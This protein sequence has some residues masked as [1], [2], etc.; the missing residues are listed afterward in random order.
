MAFRV[1]E[2][3]LLWIDSVD[4]TMAMASRLVKRWVVGEA[5]ELKDTLL[6]AGC[7]TS[8][9]GRGEHGWE[10]PVGGLY[11]TWLGWVKGPQIRWVPLAAG[12]AAAEAVENVVTGRPIGIKWP[13]D[14][15]ASGK[16]L[17]GI[18]C[19]ARGFGDRHWAAVGLGINVATVPLMTAPPRLEALSLASLVPD[20]D[21]E[22]A[23]GELVGSFAVGFRRA[24]SNPVQVRME[25]ADR[26]VHR[27]GDVLFLR[28]ESGSVQGAFAGFTDDGHLKLEVAGRIRVFSA[29]ELILPLAGESGEHGSAGH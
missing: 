9:R 19:Q 25:W 23:I 14:L 13:N 7:Q 28:E 4:S 27:T 26:M 22:R 18:V 2:T 6:V 24:L 12:V 3:N 21:W 1:P 10:S 5:G 17:G 29:G 16:K 20:L 8:G 11:V 15:I